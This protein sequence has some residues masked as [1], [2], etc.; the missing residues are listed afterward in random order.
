MRD[1]MLPYSEALRQIRDEGGRSAEFADRVLKKT[2]RRFLFLDFD[3]VLNESEYLSRLK[4]R[5]CEASVESYSEMIDPARVARL[6]AIVEGTCALIVISSS[7]RWV[8][9]LPQ[10]TELLAKRGSIG[11]VVGVTPKSAILGDDIRANEIRAWLGTTHLRQS[12]GQPWWSREYQHVVL[13]DF[14][15][16]DLGDGS[17]VHVPAGLE[18]VHVKQAIEILGGVR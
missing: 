18:D 5:I 17:F 7:W 10:L 16:A 14:K 1:P 11:P 3:G 4:G 12:P 9:N 13:D 2:M 15:D 6:N 8:F